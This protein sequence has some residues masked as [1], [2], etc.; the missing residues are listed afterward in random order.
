MVGIVTV[1]ES[2]REGRPI[3]LQ[4]SILLCG[5][6][7]NSLLLFNDAF[8]VIVRSEVSFPENVGESFVGH[9]TDCR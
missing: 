4:S 1:N 8:Y 9:D 3:R 5:R 2:L 6:T 7:V